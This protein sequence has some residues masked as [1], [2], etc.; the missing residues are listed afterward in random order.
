MTAVE[1]EHFIDAELENN[2]LLEKAETGREYADICSLHETGDRE[3][4]GLNSEDAVSGI[5][6]MADIFDSV[7]E[8]VYPDDQ[9]GYRLYPDC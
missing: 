2:P 4:G 8:N 5:D 9:A 7:L 6:S 1:L 3:Q